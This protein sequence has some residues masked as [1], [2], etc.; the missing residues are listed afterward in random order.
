MR[1]HLQQFKD[2]EC[3]L[4]IGISRKSMIYKLVNA[5]PE[6]TDGLSAAL[7]LQAMQMGANIVRVHDVEATAKIRQLFLQL[8]G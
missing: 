2:L 7:H 4:M 5:K 3:P 6:D 1:E 8:N